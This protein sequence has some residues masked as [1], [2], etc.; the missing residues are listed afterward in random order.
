[1]PDPMDFPLAPDPLA[2]GFDF[3]S[4][5]TPP[6][7][8]PQTQTPQRGIRHNPQDRQQAMKL[9]ILLPLAL[10]AGPGAVTGLLQG[11]SQSQQQEYERGRQSQLDAS[12]QEQRDFQRQYQQGQLQNQRLQQ[13]QKFVGDFTSGLEGLDS[14][15][16]IDA[17][18]KLQAQIG[19]PYGVTPEQLS[20]LAAPYREPSR[21]QRRAADTYIKRLKDQYGADWM[22][23]AAGFTHTVGGERLTLDQVLE[24]AGQTRDPNAPQAATKPE[25]RSLDVQ[26]ADALARGDTA[27]YQR[28]LRVKREMGQADDRGPDPV[29]AEMRR[30]A[31]ERERNAPAIPPKVQQQVQSQ[32]KAF[33]SNQV[34]KNTQTMAEAASFVQ[35]LDPNT[36]NPA[37]DQALIYAFAKAMDPNSVVREGEYATVQKYAQSWLQSF[38]FNAARVLSN[39]EFLTPQA[40]QNMKRTVLQRFRAAQA[41]Y[42]AVRDSYAKKIN[43]LTGMQD[44]ADYL[45]GYD[46]AFP[47][48][49]A[50]APAPPPAQGG[51]TNRVGRFE[52]VGVK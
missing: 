35:S 51:G 5:Q 50:P 14:P 23:T 28:L 21:L 29:L 45:T 52:I 49:P 33:D 2:Q 37:D 22:E 10:K 47:S 48:A 30:L 24:R 3:G 39:T 43:K 26:A 31:L 15:E 41:Q 44:G 36:K 18:L 11:F 25:T 8:P 40:R 17:Y 27:T 38:G 1:M 7:V 42:N 12:Q 19:Q 34:V 16:A 9:A 4:T 32:A 46:T 6:F 20:G 13:R